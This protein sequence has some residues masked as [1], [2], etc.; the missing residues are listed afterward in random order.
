MGTAWMYD[1]DGVVTDTLCGRE[2]RAV[3]FYT[4]FFL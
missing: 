1:D 3:G 4:F 2:R